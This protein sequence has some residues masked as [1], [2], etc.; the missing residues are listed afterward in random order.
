MTHNIN[1]IGR[2]ALNKKVTPS[3]AITAKALVAGHNV[4]STARDLIQFDD[5]IASY[6]SRSAG[7]S[8]CTDE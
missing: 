1:K 4:V 5:L 3:R 2:D 8:R 7:Q 6:G